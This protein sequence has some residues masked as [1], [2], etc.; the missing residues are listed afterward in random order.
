MDRYHSRQETLNVVRPF[1]TKMAISEY[2]KAARWEIVKSATV[3][4]FREIAEKETGGR[5]IYR[6][7]EDKAKARVF[8]AMEATNW[9]KVRRGERDVKEYKEMPTT[10]KGRQSLPSIG[11]QPRKDEA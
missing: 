4:F 11:S 7:T 2:N 1:L 5:P 8:K 3:K 10:L 6:S 9:F